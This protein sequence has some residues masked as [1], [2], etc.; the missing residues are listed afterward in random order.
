MR[1][2]LILMALATGCSTTDDTAGAGGQFGEEKGPHCEIASTTP[3]S[4][5]D[6]SALGFSVDQLH[7]LLPSDEAGTLTWEDGTAGYTLT[8]TASEA[9]GRHVEQVFVEGTNGTEIF[10]DCP[11]Y[12]EFDATIA[13]STDD[14]RLAETLQATLQA[15]AADALSWWTELDS[16]TGSLAVVDFAPS[17]ADDYDALRLFLELHLDASGSAGT[18]SGQGEGSDGDTVWAEGID[19]GAW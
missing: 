18:L 11:P 6:A 15:T 3:V 7:A 12:L 10:M 9:G 8:A 16:V 19:I 2:T 5:D 13:L 1:T 4:A 14:G 17:P